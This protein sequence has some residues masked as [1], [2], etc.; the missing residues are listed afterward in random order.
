MR[1][2]MIHRTC[3]PVQPRQ[4][5]PYSYTRSMEVD[6]CLYHKHDIYSA[7]D[8]CHFHNYGPAHADA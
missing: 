4:N 7:C 3:V 6:L 8:W 1:A 2:A 5:H